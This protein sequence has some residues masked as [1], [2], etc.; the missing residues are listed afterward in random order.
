MANVLAIAPYREISPIGEKAFNFIVALNRVTQAHV[1]NVH[2]SLENRV[3]DNINIPTNEGLESIDICAM[4]LRPENFVKTQHHSLGVFEPDT[5][6]NYFHKTHLEH[7]DTLAVYSEKQ[8]EI[9]KSFNS[10]IK[11]LRPSVEIKGDLNPMKG[12][13]RTVKFYTPFV[14]DTSNRDSIVKAYFKAFSS[15]DNVAL[16]ILTQDPSKDIEEINK[17]KKECSKGAEENY[18]EI[19]L[20]TDVKEIHRQCHVCID[21]D[22]T[23]RVLLGTLVALKFGNPLVCLKTSSMQEWLPEEV[24]YKM[25]SREELVFGP[26]RMFTC[27]GEVWQ[28]FSTTDLSQMLLSIYKDRSSLRLKQGRIVSEYSD[29]FSPENSV[30]SIREAMCL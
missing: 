20:F 15:S 14:E 18:P 16:G 30:E 19:V 11:V 3:N 12:I 13:D 6:G 2:Y 8:K 4:Y 9:C 27:E 24:C 23:Y 5:K 10:N 29:L 21:V 1:H 17:L 26:N 28:H 25:P 7:L 22:S